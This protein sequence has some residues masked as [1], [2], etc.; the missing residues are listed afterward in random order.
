[1][2]NTTAIIIGV[3]SLIACIALI[4]LIITKFSIKNVYYQT[5]QDDELIR[6][7]KTATSINDL[8]FTHGQ[9]LNYIKKYVVCSTG[10]DKYVICNYTGKFEKI[11]YFI[12]S[13]NAKKKPIGVMRCVEE[14]TEYSSHVIPLT[15]NAKYV[16]VVIGKV[17]DKMFNSNVIKPIAVRRVKMH[18]LLCSLSFLTGMISAINLF[19]V[20]FGG[21]YSRYI[22]NSAEYI[23]MMISALVLSLVLFLLQSSILRKKNIKARVGGVIEYEFI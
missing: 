10:Q 14:D 4:V 13:Y 7:Q 11:V 21:I 1:M 20:I 5:Y 23:I 6:Q 19:A 3:I 17:N 2:N 8:Y 12:I 15:K 18:S 22:L 16:N 9:T